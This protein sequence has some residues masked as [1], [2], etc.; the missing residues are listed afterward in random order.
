M[1]PKDQKRVQMPQ[2]PFVAWNAALLRAYFSPANCGEHVLLATTRDALDD[3]APELGGY[4]GLLKA[5]EQGPPWRVGNTMVEMARC[6][7]EQRSGFRPGSYVDPA[8]V[9]PYLSPEDRTPTYL[10]ILAALVALRVEH[11]YNDGGFFHWSCARLPRLSWTN[12]TGS[13]SLERINRLWGDLEKWTQRTRGRFGW[14]HAAQLGGLAN[15][16][17][18]SAQGIFRSSDLERMPLVLADIRA[19]PGNE[20]DAGL[21][22]ALLQ[23]VAREPRLSASLRAAANPTAPAAYREIIF[24]RASDLAA[25]WDGYVPRAE[26]PGDAQGH[27]QA[28]RG[29]PRD[30]SRELGIVLHLTGSQLPWKMGWRV[31]ASRSDAKLRIT[32]H[33]RSWEATLDGQ[34]E[35]TA[36]SKLDIDTSVMLEDARVSPTGRLDLE[37]RVDETKG[38]G[39]VFHHRPLRYLV[40]EGG[41]SLVEREALPLYG[42]G[43]VLCDPSPHGDQGATELS[44]RTGAHPVATDGLPRGWRLLY[45][46]DCSRVANLVL[47]DGRDVPR[48]RPPMKLVGGVS[49]RR[50]GRL[51]YLPYDL[52]QVELDAPPGTE[53]SAQGLRLEVVEAAVEAPGN[54]VEGAPQCVPSSLR[55]FRIGIED[56][57]MQQFRIQVRN[58]NGLPLQE[59][60]LRVAAVDLPLGGVAAPIG[61]DRAGSSTSAT[62]LL[63]GMTLNPEPPEPAVPR[64][65]A[66]RPSDLGDPLPDLDWF[67]PRPV[68]RF[69]DA[70]AQSS[71]RGLPYGVAR[72]RL[73][74]YLIASNLTTSLPDVFRE[75][76]R[77]GHIEVVTDHRG[78]WESIA[79]V[80]PMLWRLAAAVDGRPVWGVTG[81]LAFRHW[82]ALRQAAFSAYVQRGT[83]DSFPTVRLLGPLPSNIAEVGFRVSK[84][85]CLSIAGFSTSLPELRGTFAGGYPTLPERARDSVE[86]F[87]PNDAKWHEGQ[88][89]IVKAPDWTLL[90]Y[91]DPDTG[92]HSLRTLRH[93][94]PDRT[95][96]WHVRDERWGTWIAYDASARFFDDVL[97]S[98]GQAATPIAP[99]PL[100]YDE[101]RFQL[102]VPRRMSFPYVLERALVA[103]SG[104]SPHAYRLSREDDPP[105]LWGRSD[106]GTPIGPFNGVYDRLLPPGEP[107]WWLAYPCVPRALADMVAQKL[108]CRI[109]HLARHKGTFLHA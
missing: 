24:A 71:A 102:W 77:Q 52:P 50:G 27:E 31:G 61:L 60:T 44:A 37:S 48:Q 35:V 2:S 81:T 43:Y 73:R 63:C 9:L 36:T 101:H 96:H 91:T 32:R 90:R 93:A 12:A 46:V 89:Q 103:A 7:C 69:L 94:S 25:E 13:G 28:D 22:H 23:A 85:T 104:E 15:L 49:V 53:V 99:W 10:P 76:R 79:K 105:Q 83:E 14:F 20:L 62:P 82:Q 16:G 72:D 41:T 56:D 6:L 1:R 59:R 45:I 86:C 107:R 8:S 47:P 57:R 55:R 33:N 100:H 65:I 38:P 42:A 29:Q 68:L 54:P 3:L 30:F 70:L 97:K 39:F 40:A 34:P 66:L 51:L 26:R 11:P 88:G 108:G 98:R 78:R 67:Q 75:L 74:R 80:P 64:P 17:K 95:E 18:L 58:A 5:V 92:V 21:C 106:L 4:E 87:S 19:P 109:E 84:S